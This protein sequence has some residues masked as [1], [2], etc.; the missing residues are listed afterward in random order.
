MS[1]L[2]AAMLRTTGYLD[3]RDHLTEAILLLLTTCYMLF[4]VGYIKAV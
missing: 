2:R 4:I 1:I 3:H